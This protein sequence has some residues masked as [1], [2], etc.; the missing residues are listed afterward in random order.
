MVKLR[1]Y[2]TNFTAGEIS[3]HLLGRGDLRAYDN[4]AMTLS[5]VFVHPTGGVRRRP[6]LRYLDTLS[7]KTRLVAF[8]FNT[9][10][11]YLL[12]FSDLE[13]HVYRDDAHVATVTTPWSEAQLDQ[14]N[15]V[16]SA[17]TLLIVHP[18]VSPRKLTRTSDSSWTLAEWSFIEADDRIYQPHFKFADDDVTLTPSATSGSITL[19]ASA[20]VFDADHVGVRLRLV[21][22]E[23]EIT[24]YTSATEAQADVKETLSGTTATKDWEE[25]SFSA[26]RGWP[27]SVCF[28]QDRLVIG[29]ARDLPNRL[30]MSKSSDL[31]NFDLGEGLDDES[32][33]FAMLADQV[34]AIRAV[35]SGRHLQVFTSGAE[36]MATG[37]PLTP[38]NVQLHRQTRVGSPIDRTVPPR[39]V[40]GA[41][42]FIPRDGAGLREFLFADVEQAYQSNDLATLAPHM[43]RQPVDLDYHSSARQL[44]VVDEDG[45]LST[46]TIYRTEKV[47]AWSSQST[48]GG[49]RS[50]SVVDDQIYVVVERNGAWFL[51]KFDDACHTDA[52]LTGTS[53]TPQNTWSGLDHLE[54]LTVTI[55]A[56]GA[57]H[58]SQSVADGAIVLEEE[59]SSVEIGLAFDH[60][61]EPLPPFIQTQ[62][63]GSLGVR[64][65]PVSFTFRL[66]ESHALRLDSG[67]GFQEIPFKRLGSG[68]LDAAPTAYT[69]D[70]TV[71][72]F[73]WRDSGLTP[74]WTIQHDAPLPFT[75][76]AVST[77]LS[78]NG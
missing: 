61:I 9:E 18:D 65:R 26:I 23:V 32:I 74:L 11:V 41:T 39:D 59:A 77:E 24:G 2:K 44:H 12:A 20:D 36:W 37:D 71:R 68:V 56:D 57:V 33:E 40:D 1:S 67:R 66:H 49:F 58:H 53:E 45:T 3:P 15:W 72:A 35:F 7:G 16:Q 70:R 10:Q 76:L 52:A 64:L 25:Q 63:G 13:I 60:S 47:T 34:N 62:G 54:G 42:L 21:N 8:E 43:I 48:Q 17:D 78:V 30:W 6:G 22:K 29:G 55:L 27:V 51:E 5:N 14:I 19:T 4:G 31:F 46:V 75:L 38:G 73:G 69:G 50:L 28:H